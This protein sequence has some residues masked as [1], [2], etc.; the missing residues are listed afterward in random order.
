MYGTWVTTRKYLEEKI[1]HPKFQG[2]V[3]YLATGYKDSGDQQAKLCIMVD[4]K[5]AL[6]LTNHNELQAI[7]EAYNII[8]QKYSIV[9][10]YN[11]EQLYKLGYIAELECIA[12][13]IAY[14][15]GLL[16]PTDLAD[17]IEC[18]PELFI[19]EAL[20]YDDPFVRLLAVLDK[21]VGEEQKATITRELPKQPNW[22]KQFYL[23][24]LG[25]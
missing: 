8:Q 17:A 14:K 9:G 16:T 20:L 1:L 6:F 3:A 12:Q 23:L 5:E 24:G 4:G 25:E 19:D 21:R 22:L 18:Y 7:G 11:S 15:K 2:R 10:E 13:D